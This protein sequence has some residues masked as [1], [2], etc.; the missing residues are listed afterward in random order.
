MLNVHTIAAF[1]DNYIWLIH[2][3]NSLNAYVVDPGCGQTVIDYVATTDLNLIGILI[4]IL[5]INYFVATPYSVAG[6]DVYSKERL[7]KCC[8]R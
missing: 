1:N 5:T 7:S 4:I 8:I 3:T 6:V 2:Q